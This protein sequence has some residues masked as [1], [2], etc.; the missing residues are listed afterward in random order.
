MRGQ[1]RSGWSGI[2][3]QY[4]KLLDLKYYIGFYA[5][6]NCIVVVSITNGGAYASDAG[7][8]DDTFVNRVADLTAW[9]AHDPS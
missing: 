5:D 1:S 7:T 2:H 9:R 6:G 4:K 3:P 8:A